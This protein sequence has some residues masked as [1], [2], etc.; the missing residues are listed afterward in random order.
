MAAEETTDALFS[1]SEFASEYRI[2]ERI[3]E[4]GFG[5]VYRAT[6]ERTGQDVAV[7]VMKLDPQGADAG[8]RIQRFR[9][10]MK[11]CARL[12]HPNIVRLI[13]SGQK[14]QGDQE[15][16]FTVFEYVPGQTLREL[17]DERKSLPP[18]VAKDLMLQVLEALASAHDAGVLHRDLK[19]DNIMLTETRRGYHAK[20]LDFGI[21]TVFGEHATD[22]SR[23]TASRGFVGTYAYAAPE[24]LHSQEFTT[25]SDLY[26]WGL[27]F[28]ETLQG[29]RA[30]PGERVAQIVFE[31][32]SNSPICIPPW[33]Q[34][35][36][37]GG[38][39]ERVLHK[40]PASREKD[41]GRLA[42]ELAQLALT[43][44]GQEQSTA[45]SMGT[46]A[47][48]SWPTAPGYSEP[49]S[50]PPSVPRSDFASGPRSSQAPVSAELQSAQA[51]LARLRQLHAVEST[52][53][54]KISALALRLR[55]TNL[56][57][58]EALRDVSET[59]AQVMNS[60]RVSVWLVA[61]DRRSIRCLDL[62]ER[63]TA[64]H[65]SGAVLE[66]SDYPSYFTALKLNR[67]LVVDDVYSHD[68]TRELLSYCSSLG[69][70][71][72][73][74]APVWIGG[75]MHG[76]LCHEHVGAKRE[77]TEEEGAHGGTLAD[78]ASLILS[79][80]EADTTDNQPPPDFKI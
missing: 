37:L 53:R 48:R 12:H 4:G 10:E 21:S 24:H 62:Y 18:E 42:D 78:L 14:Q 44:L 51:D 70:S 67:A 28:L 29:Q 41:A 30:I 23:I 75:R 25:C 8:T 77:W 11:L 32:M 16:L 6:Q 17:L 46:L 39:L 57:V 31:Q 9:R 76:V 34:S 43:S 59:A 66:A 15:T 80:G 60:S 69:I 61:P 27:T 71:S 1:D 64:Q 56:S 73:L 79:S 33:L 26:A 38:L 50:T 2:H 47:G 63:D 22:L 58:Q 5:T 3:G 55:Q 40:N 36:C 65:Q 54:K 35:H 68:S 13:D 45:E 74:D 49:H 52:R 7:K 20:L 19:P 72:M